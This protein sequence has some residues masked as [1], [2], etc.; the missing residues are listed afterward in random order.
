[1]KHSAKKTL[2]RKMMSRQEVLDRVAPFQSRAWRMRGNARAIKCSKQ[3]YN[4]RGISKSLSAFKDN[5]K[6][7]T[8]T[9]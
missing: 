9:T 8:K 3:A 4:I 6:K 7:I 2:A 5:I 1:M